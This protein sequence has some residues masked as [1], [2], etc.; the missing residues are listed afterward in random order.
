MAGNYL[1]TKWIKRGSAG[2]CEVGYL[3]G[4]LVYTKIGNSFG[5]MVVIPTN[6]PAGSDGG[7]AV[8]VLDPVDGL[9]LYAFA[10]GGAPAVVRV[11]KYNTGTTNWDQISHTYH[12]WMATSAVGAMGGWV[13]I[14]GSDGKSYFV[15]PT[16]VAGFYQ[17]YVTFIRFDPSNA[18]TPIAVFFTASAGSVGPLTSSCVFEGKL[19]TVWAYD[20]SSCQWQ[21]F[22]PVT[23]STSGINSGAMNI[24]TAPYAWSGFFR[25]RFI[26]TIGKRMFCTGFMNNV[27][28]GS[29][30]EGPK[31]EEYVLGSWVP[32]GRNTQYPGMRTFR[33]ALT[34][35]PAWWALSAT[36][37]LV[38][39]S[40]RGD[41][42]LTTTAD[43]LYAILFELIGGAV[44]LTDV[45]TTVIPSY[46]RSGT[47]VGPAGK[48]FGCYGITDLAE[49]PGTPKRYMYFAPSI[50]T[51]DASPQTWSLFEIQF[52]PIA[53]AAP[54]V[55][56]LSE[57]TLLG[58]TDIDTQWNPPHTVVG[59]G[60]MV[61]APSGLLQVDIV[62][63]YQDNA[64]LRVEFRAG[65]DP[66][67]SNKTVRFRF[68]N[69]YG[70]PTQP[71]TLVLGSATGGGATVV[72]NDVQ[73]VDANPTVLYSVVWD[74]IADGVAN[75]SRV[76][77]V[78]ELEA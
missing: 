69:S 61:Y 75:A 67:F 68:A 72:G 7:Q 14:T 21:T 31:L 36:K 74:F 28:D 70:S 54:G 53:G 18:V 38:I 16:R 58:A 3:A 65:G 15:M 8:A 76:H 24:G 43:G 37:T 5:T 44:V 25:H 22:D 41:T 27:F 20:D 9:E 60:E 47:L 34:P 77:L 73:N 45:S 56:G 51:G 17:N 2:A 78:A 46:L 6:N 62:D 12:D 63:S 49:V 30:L 4:G 42:T 26:F 71:A 32:L 35:H 29:Y 52:D 64:G 40:G 13:H 11:W 50:D 59:G 66:G 1:T 39:T 33:N 19:H 55:A 57:M 10:F 48:P 23:G